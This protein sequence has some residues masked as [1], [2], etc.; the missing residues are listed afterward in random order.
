M[1]C[2]VGLDIGSTTTKAVALDTEGNLL[3]EEVLSTGG[4]F[5]ERA[6]AILSKVLSV[7]RTSPD[8]LLWITATGYG[9]FRAPRKDQLITELS[10]HARGAFYHVKRKATVVDIGGQDNKILEIDASGRRGRTKMNRKCAAG[11]GAFIE[12]AA[13]QIGVECREL[14]NLSERSD[15]VIQLGSFCTVFA[16]TE[17]IEN[18]RLGISKENI[19]RGV[20]HA[21]ALRA[22]EMGRFIGEVVL[23]GGVAEYFPVVAEELRNLSGCVVTIPPS[24]QCVG[25]LGAALYGLEAIQKREKGEQ[26]FMELG[27]N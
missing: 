17:I 21:V 14:Q 5:E 22:F 4:Y 18:L 13:R 2:V 12:N 23:T 6:D 27:E 11:T 7:A 15:K 16:A 9:R 1:N 8:E 24:P 25:A 19:A 3:A 20:M 26:P 10:C